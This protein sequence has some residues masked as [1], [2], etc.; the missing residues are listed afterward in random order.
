MI[1]ILTG[2]TRSAGWPRVVGLA[3]RAGLV[4][5]LSTLTLD[6]N[7]VG[8]AGYVRCGTDVQP[9]QSTLLTPSELSHGAIQLLVSLKIGDVLL[10]YSYDGALLE[11]VVSTSVGFGKQETVSYKWLRPPTRCCTHS[12]LYTYISTFSFLA[13]G[14]F[15]VS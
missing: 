10:L 13:C 4:L 2:F 6:D 1:G 8:S 9:R 5:R 7:G 11:V 15:H 3:F 14:L 12:R